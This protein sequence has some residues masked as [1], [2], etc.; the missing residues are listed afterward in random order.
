MF[1]RRFNLL[2]PIVL[3]TF[4]LV[5]ATEAAQRD[6]MVHGTVADSTGA[7]LPGARLEIRN[8][9]TGA[10]RLTVS[11]SSGE[12]RFEGMTPGTYTLAVQRENFAPLSTQVNVS[13]TDVRVPISLSVSRDSR[14][15]ERITVVGDPI[16]IGDIP[17][18]ASLLGGVELERKKVGFDDV[19]RFLRQI[20]GVNIQE[21]E[22]YGLRPNISMRGS[23]TE[24]SSTITLLEDGVPIAPAPYAAAAAYYFPT[25]GRM[26]AIEV[27]KG[28]SQIKYG[29]RTN[30]GALNLISTPIPSSLR[31]GA[32]LTMGGDSTRKVH[33]TLGDSS[34]H[35]G[36]LAETYQFST[37]G[38]K[39]IDGGGDS[40]FDLEDYVLKFRMNTGAG[41]R[42]Y[43]Q[44]EVKLGYTDQRSD[45]TYL[46]LSDADFLQNPFRRYVGSQED[47]FNSIHKQY[48]VRHFAAFSDRIDVTTTVYR[49]DFSRNWYKLNDVNGRAISDVLNSPET[50][51]TEFAII[52]GGDSPAGSLRVRANNRSYY[53]Y[54]VESVLGLRADSFGA[55]NSFEAGLRYH[56]DQEDRF[57][58][59]DRYQMTTGRMVQTQ[60]GAP[61]SQDNR[62]G[63]AQAWAFFVQDQIEAGRWTVTPGLRYENIEVVRT[64][65]A[66]TGR[67]SSTVASINQVDVFIPGV[68]VTFQA[69]PQFGLFAGVHRGFAPPG[70]G[71]T[72]E[73]D[74]ESSVNYE[75]GFR[76]RHRSLET[77]AAFFLNDYRNLLGRDT[78]SSGGSGSGLL[79]N[80][81]KARVHGL[82]ASLRYDLR[83]LWDGNLFVP[84]HF[85]YT[86]THGEFRSSFVSG[87]E[88]WGTVTSGDELPYLPEHQLFFGIGVGRSKWNIDLDGNYVGAT[89]V[90][91]G[92]GP[93]PRVDSTDAHVVFNAGADYEVGE[94]ARLFVAVQNIADNEYV[95]ARHPSGAR[96]GLPRT[97]T[98]GIRFN[99]GF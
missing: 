81:G 83:D 98:G 86:F 5:A 55:T 34:E 51:A 95:V 94:G 31:L 74:V 40:G 45:E 61:G 23:G 39:T 90:R 66:N 47:V 42:I 53:A 49:N 68:G 97:L 33:A 87:F 48:Q 32:N 24:R 71:S 41:A 77:Q 72:E 50:F 15:N 19:H 54:G 38:F 9:T 89:R 99:L 59:D 7:V 22:G 78:L 28:S 70:P 29:P 46:G 85:A 64:N 79:F 18:S 62:W 91:A 82:E 58:H 67:T 76:S 57:Q 11:D 21:E 4:L 52:R 17:G 20:P 26:N 69:V 10:V 30:G 8:S 56:K 80:G 16:G 1:S 35:F 14:L 2:I 63:D 88:P 65:F 36:W 25:P 84:V 6:S 12:F 44:A 60:S 73:T 43:Q 92:S 93:I 13:S 3:L 27:R 75:F 96:P 37:N